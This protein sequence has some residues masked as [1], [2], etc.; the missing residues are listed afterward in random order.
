[1]TAE[2]GLHP[3]GQLQ[4]LVL[5]QHPGDAALAALRV[6]A[7]H[8]FVIATQIL[9]VDRQIG[10]F[11]QLVIALLLRRKPLFD[12]VL[13]RSAERGEHQLADIGL[14]RVRRDVGAIFDRLHNAVDVGEIEAGVYP[15][16]VHVERHRHE[17]DIAGA[18]AIAEQTALHPV[19]TREQPKFRRRDAGPAIIVCVERNHHRLAIGDV[20]PEPFDLVGV[21]IGRRAFDGGGQVENDRVVRCRAQH[22]HHCRADFGAELDFGGRESLGRIFEMPVSRGIFRGL[23]A[24]DHR[25][26]DG[27]LLDRRLVHPEHDLAPRRAD[28]VIDMDDGVRGTLQTGKRRLD[29]VAPRLGQHLHSNVVGNVVVPHQPRN[30][31]KLGRA[32]TREPNLDFLDANAAKQ[33]EETLLLLRI[34]RVDQRLIAVAHVGRQPARCLRDDFRRP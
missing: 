32:R 22:V 15:L 19:G 16:R 11:P 26:V 29:Q 10:H 3:L 13:M 28:R 21:D 1:M 8:R 20:A 4:P 25:R 23:I 5:L 17:I 14:A 24:Q 27:D 7:D 33:V 18:F 6:H 2:I 9:G 12:R 34:H 31:I 30:E